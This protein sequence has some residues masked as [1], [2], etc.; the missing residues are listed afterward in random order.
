MTPEHLT[1]QLKEEAGRLGFDLA[2]ACEAVEPTGY[3]R[4]EQWL[5]SGRAGRMAYLADRREAYRH[6]GGVLDGAKSLLMLAVGYRSAEPA[7]PGPDQGRI[8]R[9]AWGLDYHEWIHERL[10]RLA[11]FH[12]EL[13]P[14]VKVRGVVDTAPLFEREFARR[15]GLGWIGRNTMVINRRWGSWILLA[16]LLTTETLAYDE[17]SADASSN[18][19][20]CGSCR[21]CLDAC[22]TGALVAPHELDARRCVSYLLVGSRDAIDPSFRESLGDRVFG[23]DACQEACPWNRDAAVTDE[24]TFW[25]RD[26][27]NPVDLVELLAMDEEAFRQQFRSTPLWQARRGG[28][29]RNAA[30]ALGNRPPLSPRAVAALCQ[31][32]NDSDSLVREASA[33]AL[34]R[35]PTV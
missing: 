1:A 3:P 22:P 30:I 4:F 28:I 2:G 21:A 26:G 34:G 18:A 8:S 23:C 31:R 10:H 16:A 32:L 14:G 25:P 5:A 29:L 7:L 15:A 35:Q 19:S 13:T 6:P 24:R 17:P 33:W 11:D 9:Y 12:R 20:P 27:A